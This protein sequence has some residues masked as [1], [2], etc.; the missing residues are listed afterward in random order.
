[1][2]ASGHQAGWQ[3]GAA[4]RRLLVVAAVGAALFGLAVPTAPVA[5]T[6]A[7]DYSTSVPAADAERGLGQAAA[8]RPQA[9]DLKALAK[10]RIAD[11]SAPPATPI[12]V[13]ADAAA[14]AFG[15]ST[16]PGRLIAD[17]RPA[18]RSVAAQPRAPPAIRS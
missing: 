10:K 5:Q 11:R 13:V 12:P 2:S 14:P 1:M 6:G 18:R 16:L 9:Q 3:V 7:P 4:L 15:A 17:H 8:V